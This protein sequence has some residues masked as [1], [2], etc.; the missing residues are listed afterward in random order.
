MD[1]SRTILVLSSCTSRKVIGARSSKASAER[2]Y[3]G[4]QHRR[5]MRGVGAFRAADCGYEIDLRILSAGF[6]LVAGSRRL[7]L[8]DLSFAGLG[9]GA[10]E[11]R[12]AELGIPGALKRILAR[13]H[14]L[15]I[16]LLGEDYMRAAAIGP[17]TRFGGPAIAFGG[18]ALARRS[19]SLPLRVVPATKSEA[20]RFSC[21]LVGLKGELGGRL[22]ALLSGEPSLISSLPDSDAELLGMLDRV[23]TQPLEVTA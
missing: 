22:L 19:V 6:G 20:R 12:S 2:L 14:A 5:L 4:E 16:L 18:A 17:T 21:G 11:E 23:S 15:T 8:Y 9:G 10:I 7:P 13:S 3:V 1:K